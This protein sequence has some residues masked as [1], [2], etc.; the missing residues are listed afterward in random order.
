MIINIIDLVITSILLWWILTDILMEEKLRIQYVWSIV[1]TIIVILAEIGCSF[2][3]NTTPDNRI[4]SQIFNVIGFSISPFILLVE[5]I[6]NENRIHRSWLYLPAVVNALLT[7]SSPLTGFIFFVSQEGTYNRGFLFPI[8]LATFV[9]SVVISMYNKVLSVRKMPDHF[10]QRIIVTNIILLGGIMI[11]VFMPDMH[12]TWL[13]V[14]I[15]LL[16]NYTVSCE[17]ASMID[18]L[19]KLINRTGFNM[20]APKMKPERRGITVLFMI[21]VNNFKNVNDEKGHTFGD[22]CLREIA[23][24]LRRTF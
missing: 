8:Y 13:T 21:D 9:F 19:T 22:Y 16:L 11:Q 2:Y 4:W 15:Y 5:S 12:V 20:M 23:T 14:S 18:G 7:I 10:I 6:R 1:F 24:I 3:D 17:I